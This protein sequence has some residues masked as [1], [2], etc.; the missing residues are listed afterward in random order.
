MILDPY[1]AVLAE[2]CK[3]GDDI[4]IANLDPALR[5]RCTGV[6]WIRTR[7]PELYSRLAQPTGFEEDTRR[8]RFEHLEQ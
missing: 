6:R 5:E 2:T 7:R 4:V 8:V 3:A 1:G